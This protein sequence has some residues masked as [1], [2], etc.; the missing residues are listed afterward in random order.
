MNHYTLKAATLL[1]VAA[2][3]FSTGNCS[4]SKISGPLPQRG[5]LW[6]REWTPAVIDA[7]KETERRMDGIVLLGAEIDWIG[8]KAEVVRVTIDWKTVIF[9]MITIKGIYGRQMYETW[10]QMSNL[11][12]SGVDIS[13]VITHR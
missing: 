3:T 5:Y 10:Y 7:F 6:Q 12:D 9:N 2:I 1:C 8:N 13:P 4:R 11:V